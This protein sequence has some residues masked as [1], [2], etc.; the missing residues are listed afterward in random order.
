MIK[1]VQFCWMEVW[2]FIMQMV[3]DKMIYSGYLEKVRLNPSKIRY[4]DFS[5]SAHFPAW[6][7][8][9]WK[10]FPLC[11]QRTWQVLRAVR[12]ALSPLASCWIL[13]PTDMLSACWNY[14]PRFVFS[15][16]WPV[17]ILGPALISVC[18]L[19]VSPL[20]YSCPFPSLLTLLPLF[21]LLMKHRWTQLSIH[22]QPASTSYYS[23]VNLRQRRQPPIESTSS[24]PPVF[25]SVTALSWHFSHTKVEHFK[26]GHDKICE[27]VF[28]C[29][30][31]KH[32]KYWL[33]HSVSSLFRHFSCFTSSKAPR[34]VWFW[35]LPQM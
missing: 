20:A 6:H 35:E 10:S 7:L 12:A 13:C 23:A 34:T 22:L 33:W 3:L 28:L 14:P 26:H 31:A 2:L 4:F 15:C 24:P 32:R 27:N 30:R 11:L 17:L 25:D 21:P 16:K 9:K 29:G 5:L 18:L 19:H 1:K 8:E